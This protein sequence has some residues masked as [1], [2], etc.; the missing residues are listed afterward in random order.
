MTAPALDAPDASFIERLSAHF[1]AESITAYRAR[2]DAMLAALDRFRA[3]PRIRTEAERARAWTAKQLLGSLWCH[4]VNSQDRRAAEVAGLE[5]QWARALA[6]W[7][8]RLLA[9]TPE[10]RTIARYLC[11]HRHYCGFVPEHVVEVAA[12]YG[13]LRRFRR[14]WEPRRLFVGVVGLYAKVG[15][16]TFTLDWQGRHHR[17]YS[18]VCVPQVFGLHPYYEAFIQTPAGQAVAAALPPL[19]PDY[20]DESFTTHGDAKHAARVPALRRSERL[21][22]RELLAAPVRV[23]PTHG[24]IDV[25]DPGVPASGAPRTRSATELS[26][27]KHV[28]SFDAA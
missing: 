27:A 28:Q 24:A 9:R 10:A 16:N 2:Q 22:V 3:V 23:D 12:A 18:D 11:W 8:G 6:R 20:V 5:H 19:E 21:R 13:V 7:S 25:A 15:D 1:G 26:E 4:L 14:E 17:R